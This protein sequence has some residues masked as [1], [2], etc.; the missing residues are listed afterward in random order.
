[1]ASD[2][3]DELLARHLTGGFGAPR[4]VYDE[5]DSTNSEALRWAAEEGASEGA[6]VVADH[7]TAGRGRWG[8]SWLS[9]PGRA[10]MFSLVLRPDPGPAVQLLTTAVGVAVAEAVESLTGV[11]TSLKWPNDVTVGSRKLGGILVETRLTGSSV[12][13][14]VAGAGI[15][16]YAPPEEL[17]ATRAT[18]LAAELG[19]RAGALPA[20]AELLGAVIGAIERVYGLLPGRA[21]EVVQMARARSDVLGAEVMVRYGDGRTV[22]GRAEDL[23]E[24]GALAVRVGDEIV[25]VGTGEI[26]R[27]RRR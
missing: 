10:V 26:E 1:M 24:D 4:R 27:L 5:I 15:N 12:D 6:L 16:L 23:L 9:I 17:A 11:Q 18:S 3:S 8:R 19:E 20:R 7:Q 14:A 2:L 13:A 25:R 22:E 21:E